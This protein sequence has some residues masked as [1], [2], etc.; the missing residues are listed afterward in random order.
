[1]TLSEMFQGLGR[2][3]FD[4]VL[5]AVSMGALKTYKVYESFKVRVHMTKLNRDRLRKAAPR[6]WE[7]LGGGDEELARELA[8]GA[9]VSHIDLV[10]DVLDFLEI[11]HDGAGF[12]DK[13]ASDE[14]HLTDDWQKR[15]VKQFSG[16]HP[17]PL[18][19]L[20]V[21]HL[22]FELGEPTEV[23]VG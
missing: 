23:F 9:L 21:N 8:Q 7:R 12:F 20:Y 3:R 19:L 16:R 18:L 22:E 2:E 1:M 17:E 4:S 11:P 14:D 15:V 6:L 13:E 5:R 10:V